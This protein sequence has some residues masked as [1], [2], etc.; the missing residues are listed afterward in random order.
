MRTMPSSAMSRPAM[1]RSNVVMPQPDGPSSEKNSPLRMET[2]TR[3]SASTSPNLRVRF[4]TS[5]AGVSIATASGEDNKTARSGDRIFDGDRDPVARRQ[6]PRRQPPPSGIER[7]VANRDLLKRHPN[8][9]SHRLRN[10]LLQRPEFEKPVCPLLGRQR[11][12]LRHLAW[13]TD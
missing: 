6:P 4:S 12:Q 7:R 2:L 10:R 13:R 11:A 3:S 1:M 9:Q 8:A 5:I